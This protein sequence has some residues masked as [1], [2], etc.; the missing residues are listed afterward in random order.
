MSPPRGPH[1]TPA[2]IGCGRA[3][4]PVAAHKLV[5]RG[6]Y[7]QPDAGNAESSIARAC[8]LLVKVAPPSSANLPLPRLMQ[9][10]I[11]TAT[12]HRVASMYRSVGDDLSKD[13]PRRRRS[14]G[15]GPTDALASL[16]L[17]Q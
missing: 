14:A 10:R 7:G 3:Y 1:Q 13:G 15:P 4:S 8:N 17:G 16:I 6:T 12:G 5:M 2:Q 9:P 11:C